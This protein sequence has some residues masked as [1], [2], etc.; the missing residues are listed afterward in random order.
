MAAAKRKDKN[1]VVLRKGESYRENEGR[2]FYRWTDRTGKRHA[3]YAKTLDALRTKENEISK[4]I[5][6]GIKA[7]AQSITLNQIYDLW[8][9]I[10]RGLKNTSFQNYCYMYDT[11]VANSFGKNRIAAIRKSD[12]KR[13]YNSL[14]DE[15]GLATST[16]NSIH[17]IIHQ[18]FGM[19]IDDNYIRS[20]P[21][22]NTLRELKKSREFIEEKRSALTADQEKIFLEFLLENSVYRHWYPVFAI[23]IGSGL[24]VG[25]ITGLRWQ[26]VDIDNGIIDVNHTLVYYSHRI[27]KPGEKTGS[28]FA[29]NSTKTPASKRKI[30]MLDFVKEAFLMEKQYQ[31]ETEIKCA[32]TVDG[33]TDFIFV[34]SFGNVQHQGALNRAIHRVVRACNLKIIETNPKIESPVLLPHFSCHS[35]RHTF[36]TRMC[37]NGVN[38]KVIQ[39]VLGHTDISTT[40]NIY[41]D[42]TKDM[43]IQAFKSLNEELNKGKTFMTPLD[44]KNDT[45]QN[46]ISEEL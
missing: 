45:N 41:T 18:L 15:R 20:N 23:M 24:R 6:D 8:K 26:D 2:Y 22:D 37:E 33:F 44:T 34:N 39:D 28:Y 25:E 31:E 10:K 42:A 21:S 32:V 12:V 27:V 14:A 16:I 7:E 38:I 19:A 43:K 46:N 29:I 11:F 3:V 13:F 5:S 17:T 30:P 9:S 1:R 40:M 35:L 4:D 36:A